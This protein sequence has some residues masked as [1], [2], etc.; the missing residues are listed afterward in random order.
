MSLW[1]D[2]T[3]SSRAPAAT[4]FTIPDIAYVAI[5]PKSTESLP[6]NFHIKAEK[7]WATPSEDENDSMSYTFIEDFCGDPV[8]MYDFNSLQVFSNG[9][10]QNVRFGIEAFYFPGSEGMFLSNIFNHF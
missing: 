6:S 9:K 4:S 7:C 1:E 8:E 2:E 10:S 3:F 5:L